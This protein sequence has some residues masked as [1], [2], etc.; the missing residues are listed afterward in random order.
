MAA[1]S[2]TIVA[3]SYPLR[4]NTSSARLRATSR[5]S[6]WQIIAKVYHTYEG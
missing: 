6:T 1:Q 3:G 2:S 5:S 4:Q